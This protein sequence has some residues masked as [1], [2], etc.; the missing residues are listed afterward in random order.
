MLFSALSSATSSQGPVVPGAIPRGRY[1]GSV[2]ISGSKPNGL[3]PYPGPGLEVFHLIW[4]VGIQSPAESALASGP[5]RK[6]RPWGFD[7]HFV[8]SDLAETVSLLL[9]LRDGGTLLRD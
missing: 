5:N 4:A 2:E 6:G 7:L 1:A 9:L 8:A 3:R